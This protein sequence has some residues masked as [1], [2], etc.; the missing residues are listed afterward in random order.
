MQGSFDCTAHVDARASALVRALQ[1]QHSRLSRPQQRSTPA[2]SHRHAPWVA[3]GR[4]CA[5]V[6]GWVAAGQRGHSAAH[7][8]EPG[9]A[10]TSRPPVD[11]GGERELARCGQARSGRHTAPERRRQCMGRR[12]ATC[13]R[14]CCCAAPCC[15]CHFDATASRACS[16][17]LTPWLPSGWEA[18]GLAARWLNP[19]TCV[20]PRCGA[21]LGALL[22][23]GC[24]IISQEF[25]AGQGRGSLG[26]PQSTSSQLQ[27]C[28]RGARRRR[29]RSCR[30]SS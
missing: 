29:Q 2:H 4:G 28:T 9:S 17:P 8:P 24:C 3:A 30:R 1:Q 22:L 13:R 27:G 7:S 26:R 11:P 21:R 5:A 14:R 25:I 20:S 19:P 10:A 15:R 18:A 16:V 23:V 12:A 6:Q